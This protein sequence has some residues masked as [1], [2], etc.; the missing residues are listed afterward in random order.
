MA[1]GLFSQTSGL[2]YADKNLKGQVVAAESFM[3][4]GLEQILC[5]RINIKSQLVA[6][7][8]YTGNLTIK[9]RNLHTDYKLFKSSKVLFLQI[10]IIK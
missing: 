6:V 4:R 3:Q 7:N 2:K 1:L 10:K 9:L 5:T 8:N